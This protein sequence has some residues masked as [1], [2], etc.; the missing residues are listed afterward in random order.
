MKSTKHR[1]RLKKA[2]SYGIVSEAFVHRKHI[3]KGFAVI[4]ALLAVSAWSDGK[5]TMGAESL[6]GR[7]ASAEAMQAY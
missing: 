5:L 7:L 2:R 3:W 6:G 4:S 1:Q